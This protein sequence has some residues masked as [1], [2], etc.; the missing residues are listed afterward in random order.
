M[1]DAQE[2]AFEVATALVLQRVLQ[3]HVVLLQIHVFDGLQIELLT[4]KKWQIKY[5]NWKYLNYLNETFL[6][7]KYETIWKTEK[8]SKW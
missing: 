4:K 8:N 6:K 1:A 7:D 2:E 5:R 3:G